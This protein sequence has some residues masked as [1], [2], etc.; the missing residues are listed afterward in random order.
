MYILQLYYTSYYNHTYILLCSII[1][2]RIT[3]KMF[4]L[5]FRNLTLRF[6]ANKFMYL[7]NF[8]LLRLM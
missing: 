1:H 7:K 8:V 2:H 5:N 4:V 6:E 3:L